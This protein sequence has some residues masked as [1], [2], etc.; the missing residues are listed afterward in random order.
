V[1][2]VCV[3]GTTSRSGT[4]CLETWHES[5]MLCVDYAVATTIWGLQEQCTRAIGQQSRQQSNSWSFTCGLIDRLSAGNEPLHGRAFNQLLVEG[6][7][8]RA[9]AVE[10]LKVH[11]TRSA[12][13]SCFL[14]C[15]WSPWPQGWAG[16]WGSH[17]E[18]ME[19][20]LLGPALLM[21][22][23]CSGTPLP[24]AI[25]TNDFSVCHSC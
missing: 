9:L 5:I 24:P 22:R 14:A 15:W 20:A 25:T 2:H 7:G 16:I 6:S 12:V 1:R 11:E 21:A 4:C 3:E 10:Q 18:Q 17:N 8:G 13:V 23:T 19:G